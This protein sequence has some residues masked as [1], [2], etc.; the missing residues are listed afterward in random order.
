MKQTP[1]TQPLLVILHDAGTARNSPE[2]GPDIDST[3][4]GDIPG[5]FVS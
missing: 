4:P 3:L 1:W 2:L 5:G